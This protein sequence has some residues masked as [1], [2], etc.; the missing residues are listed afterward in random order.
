MVDLEKFNMDCYGG[1]ARFHEYF[2]CKKYVVTLVLSNTT[3]L[4]GFAITEQRRGGGVLHEL[5]VN[6]RR[7]RQGLG[8]ALL[9]RACSSFSYVLLEVHAANRDPGQLF[10]E[11]MGFKLR[12]ELEA[13]SESMLV[14]SCD[15]AR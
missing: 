15:G 7:R 2:S 12:P 3:G 6:V 10:Y 9:D 5:H 4:D 13:T 1:D 14:M 11:A 8:C